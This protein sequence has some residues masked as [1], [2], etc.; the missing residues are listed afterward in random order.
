MVQ[1][2]EKLKSSRVFKG[3]IERKAIA[4]GSCWKG[5]LNEG[6]DETKVTVKAVVSATGTVQ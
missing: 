4:K 1:R 5:L 2:R 3:H 6:C